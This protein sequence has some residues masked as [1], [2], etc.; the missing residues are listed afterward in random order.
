LTDYNYFIDT[1]GCP[2]NIVDSENIIKNIGIPPT[3]N[4]KKADFVI[5]NTCAFID[6]AISESINTILEYAQENKKLIVTGCLVNRFG[7]EKLKS[8]LPEVDY[9][10]YIQE[11]HLIKNLINS[12][13]YSNI[14]EDHYI[15][16]KHYY[17]LKISEGCSN[18]CSYCIIPSIRGKQKSR[19]I[20][21][22]INELKEKIK[23]PDIKEIILIAQD[24][25]AYG[26]D[27]GTNLKTLIKKINKLE[28]KKWI[29]ILYTNPEFIDY[30]LIDLIK[31]SPNILNYFDMP[32]QHCNNTILK[33]MNRNYTKENLINL[34]SY[35]RQ[36]IPDAILRT[37]VI[38]GFPGETDKRFE[39]L[40]EFIQK[41]PFE[42]LG[43][44][45]Y[46][47]QKGTLATNLRAT[48]VKKQKAE[49]RIAILMGTQQEISK[50]IHKKFT[51]KTL[52]AIIEEKNPSSKKYNFIGRTYI[53]A[54]EIDGITYIKSDKK[55]KIGDIIKVTITTNDDYDTYATMTNSLQ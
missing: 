38:L 30:E 13:N 20:E 52:D 24:T 51:N 34:Y 9:F 55:L 49:E 23:N 14:L 16:P 37:T 10:Y 8:L 19:T 47:P 33:Y 2:K 12:M 21:S 35:I 53:D 54:P 28:H 18:N 39:E 11:Q 25:T 31:D 7:R 36:H 50:N 46:Q 27:I 1:L 4:L 6:D 32:I 44:F 22:I 42:K 48:H 29:R 26:R 45:I 3:D 41:Y 40:L 17:Y 5:I 15:V 43:S